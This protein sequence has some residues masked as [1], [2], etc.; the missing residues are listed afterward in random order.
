M[1]KILFLLTLIYLTNCN[2]ECTDYNYPTKAKD[3]ISLKAD[4]SRICCMLVLNCLSDPN[5]EK[6]CIE[7]EKDF[8]LQEQIA[9][10]ESE[11]SGCINTKANIICNENEV[12]NSCY[13]KI[14][15]LLIL[16]LLF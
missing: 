2:S 3:C 13:L 4:G 8:N 5:E 12:N 1:I 16:G 6:M 10:E 7:E 14:G 9:H 15:I 11:V